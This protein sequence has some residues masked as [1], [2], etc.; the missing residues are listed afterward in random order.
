MKELFLVLI[1][2][3]CGPIIDRLV[4]SRKDKNEYA[5][6]LIETLQKEIDRLN[7][8]QVEMEKEY[9]LKYDSLLSEHNKLISKYENLKREFDKHKQK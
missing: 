9:K 4:L 2:A 8:K 1:G 6:K 7:D 5:I 3:I